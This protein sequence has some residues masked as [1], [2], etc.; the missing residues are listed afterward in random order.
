MK[1][2]KYVAPSMPEAMK[3]IR[4]EL[5]KDAVILNSK[6]VHTG[7]LFGFFTKKNIEVIAAIDPS[8][9]ANETIYKEKQRPLKSNVRE[10]SAGAVNTTT[11][12]KVEKTSHLTDTALKKELDDLKLLIKDLAGHQSAPTSI[13][14]VP[15]QK[16]EKKLIDQEIDQSIVAGLM[17][18]LLEQW[19]KNDA[20]SSQKE[21]DK[22][23]NEAFL[24][25]VK[26]FEHGGLT[27]KKQYINVVGPTGVGKTTTLAKIAA[28]CVLKHEKKVAF[29]TT[30][31]YRI[32]AI[33]QLKTYAKILN[34][35]IEVCY[36]ME[37]FITAKE[38]FS[39]FDLVFIDTAGRNFRNQQY[40]NELK[41][42]IN[43]T[44]EMETF[45]VLSLTAKL[46]DMTEIYKQFSI[47]DIQRFIFTKVDETSQYG[48]ILNLM[49][50]YKK[51]VAYIT[52]GQNVPD[53]IVESTPTV[54]VNTILGVDKE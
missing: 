40:V 23:L 28:N 31:T 51:G 3:K 36:N 16:I 25:H 44:E 19:Y 38:K 34:V 12:Q 13:Y 48:A 35:P 17:T 24:H 49:S 52:T 2:K 15:L 27:L 18:K 10:S 43:F 8:P 33:E 39:S 1:V 22:W 42:V 7:G 20:K 5:G 53:D 54:I 21:I 11:L 41:E 32:A 26:Q 50:T 14:P 37:D 45:L 6:I 9:F 46:K 29:I 47:I 30:D 4:A